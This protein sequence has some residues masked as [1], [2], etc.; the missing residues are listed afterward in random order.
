MSPALDRQEVGLDGLRDEL[1]ADLEPVVGAIHEEAVVDRLHDARPQVC[2][3]QTLAAPRP[4]GRPRR[5]AIDE[6]LERRR[7]GGQLRAI[8]GPAGGRKQAE[9]AP[10]LGITAR[11]PGDDELVQRGAERQPGQLP[12]RSEDLLGD[13]R[14]AA[15]SLRDQ[16]ECGGRG[17]LAL[18]LGHELGEIEPIQ[19]PDL[20]LRGRIWRAG[21][22]GEVR[23]ERVIARD[24]VATVGQDQAQPCGP[25]HTREERGEVPCPGVR[26]MEVLE[27]EE[28]RLAF[29][30]PLE[31][32]LDRLADPRVAPLRRDRIPSAMPILTAEPALDA[33]D[34]PGDRLGARP[35][36]AGELVI[37]ERPEPRPEALDDRRVGRPAARGYRRAPD[38]LERMAEPPDPAD[39]FGHEPARPDP[40]APGE[41][42][43]RAAAIRGR[44]QGNREMG[45][46]TLASDE[47]LAAEPRRHDPIV[48][49]RA[50][51][52]ATL[53]RSC[54][55]PSRCVRAPPRPPAR[56]RGCGGTGRS[57]RSGRPARSRSS[58][59]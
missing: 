21:D 43:P 4:R 26:V 28:H 11:E 33:G 5:H 9:H 48:P 29:A 52:T 17:P 45:E 51:P 14:V 25:G 12:P 49:H 23:L 16:E 55:T 59:R 35:E 36:H 42:Q 30:G 18:D 46:L 1:V 39:R 20:E 15:G 32:A 38:D 24:L 54:P 27:D 44:L 3:E 47:P 53:P 57:W 58:A 6:L 50:K 40:A 41:E 7:D 31:Q 22:R 34:E 56:N 37:G 8:E 13:Q 2:V 19:R 10:A